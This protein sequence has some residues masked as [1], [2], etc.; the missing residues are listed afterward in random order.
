MTTNRVLIVGGG[1]FLGRHIVAQLQAAGAAARVFGRRDYP[2]LAAQGVETFR[3][4]LADTDALTRAMTDTD[5]VFH[6]AAKVG[7]GRRRELYDAINAQGTANVIAACRAARVKKLIY[8]GTPSVVFNDHDIIDGDETLPYARK[9]LTAYVSSKITAEK[10]VLAACDETLRC[11]ALRPHLIW[12]PGD[13]NLIPRL[14]ERARHGRL[15]QIGAGKNLISVSYV[16]NTAAAHLAAW[17]ALDRREVAGRVYFV[18]EPE[19]VNCWDFIRQLLATLN[20]PPI[21]SRLPYWLA[22]AFGAVMEW[23]EYFCPNWEPPMTR[24]VAAQM[25]KSHCFKID[26]AR[27]ELNWEPQVSI[28][29]GL[30]RLRDYVPESSR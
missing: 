30:R 18:N 8:T 1:G 7:I 3:G 19:P 4:D 6:C 15:M 9:N 10:S 13:T 29:E 20:L 11:C 17:R 26:R 12:G 5:A 21:K 24:F 22:Y 16:E 25:A 23:S 28:D 27:R 14:I 2:D